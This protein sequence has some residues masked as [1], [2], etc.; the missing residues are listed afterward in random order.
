MNRKNMRII[1]AIVGA[2][3]TLGLSASTALAIGV[4]ASASVNAT[5][6]TGV[7]TAAMTRAKTR[8]DQE[9]T[10]RVTALNDLS[11]RI[12]QM[13]NISAD[14]KTTLQGQLSNQVTALTSLQSQIDVEASST[15]LKTEVQSITD[16][17]RIFALVMPQGR[18]YAAVDRISTITT[19]MTELGTKL[20]TR[21]SAAQSAGADVTV[22]NGA[23]TD[24]N[25][26]VADAKSQAQAV[27]TEVSPLVPDQGDKTVMASN[28]AAL[29]DARAKI[30][31][32]MKDLI[33]ARKDV[34][35]IRKNLPKQASA[36]ASVTASTTV[37][38]Q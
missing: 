4:S 20:Q 11:V 1:S 17:Y 10:R 36:S 33:A 32:A 15:A 31:S 14:D 22:A 30:T 28:T 35:T 12:G 2:L 25:A 8:A 6:N 19:Y 7:V 9:L 13:K 38:T 24:Y 37:T 29:K 3:L 5:V 18:I 21:I 16:S 34:D 26:K 27:I 23:M